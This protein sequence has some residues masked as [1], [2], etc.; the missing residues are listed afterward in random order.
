MASKPARKR[1]LAKI[2]CYGLLT[3]EHTIRDVP[4]IPSHET[5]KEKGGSKI[6]GG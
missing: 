3:N 2:A 5:R 1:G 6:F 4:T